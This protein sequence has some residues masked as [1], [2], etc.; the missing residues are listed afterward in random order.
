MKMF[1]CEECGHL[2]E[3]GEQKNVIDMHGFS[4]GEG[5]KYSVCPRCDGNYEEVKPCKICGS[6][7]DVNDGEFCDNCKIKVQ[8]TFSQL[9]NEHFSVEE[10]ELLNILYEGEAL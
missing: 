8:K 1:K 2:F 9:M 7:E 4:H 6:Y 3:E 5:E 10:R